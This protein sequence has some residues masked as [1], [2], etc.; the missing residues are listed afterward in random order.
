LVEFQR[1]SGSRSAFNTLFESFWELS[2]RRRPSTE[3]TE[4]FP[5]ILDKDGVLILLDMGR[6]EFYE[7]QRDGMLSLST[8]SED[9]ENRRTIISASSPVGLINLISAGLASADNELCNYSA[10]LMANLS[11]ETEM[12]DS[13]ANFLLSS[14]AVTK[15]LSEPQNYLTADTKRRCAATVFNVATTLSSKMKGSKVVAALQRHSKTPQD[16]RLQDFA[17]R[18][19]ELVSVR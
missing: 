16:P 9:S 11:L 2:G 6:S 3:E 7:C 18:T 8:Y 15:I 1:R 13:L 12:R 10:R 19:Q 5:T 14:T 17:L 4:K